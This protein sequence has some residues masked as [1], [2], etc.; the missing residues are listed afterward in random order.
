MPEEYRRVLLLV[1]SAPALLFTALFL[2]AVLVRR[3]QYPRWFVLLNPA[4][5]L[6]LYPMSGDILA[7]L[8]PYTLFVVIY[9]GFYNVGLLLFYAISTTLLWNRGVS[10]HH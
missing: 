8:L 7:R 1:V 3:T 5:L 9:G 10:L 4:F 6:V 2:F